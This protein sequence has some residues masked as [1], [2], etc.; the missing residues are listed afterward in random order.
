VTPAP[1]AAKDEKK[2]AAT[3]PLQIKIGD[4]ASVRFGILIQPQADFQ[5]NSSGDTAQNLLLRRT[6]FLVGGQVTSNVFFY[7]ETENSRL[8]AVNSA[9]SKVIS[10]G[11][12]TLAAVAEWRIKKP[13]NLQAGLLHVPTS[14]D[15]LKSAPSEFTIDSG[16]YAFTAST[17]M[18]GTSGRDTGVMARGFFLD[19][20]LEYRVA[21]LSGL[22]DSA[23]LNDFRTV[24]RLQYNVFDAEVY[25]LPSYA[26]ANFGTKKI[27]ALGVAVDSQE[28]YEGFTGDLF[29]DIPTGFG[30]AQGTVAFHQ[31]DGGTTSRTALAES[32]IL[33]ADAGLYFKKAKAGVWARYERRD[34]AASE[35]RD[36]E[37]AQLG[38]NYYPFGN[39]LNFK[40]AVGQVNPNVG[41]DMTQFTIQMQAFYY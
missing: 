14:R 21:V 40:F 6:R 39:N 15:V 7:F 27:M 33:S 37:R 5:E 19:D 30:S 2:P 10:S 12:Q 32:D 35:D 23:S 24:A 11:F 4:N 29:A 38:L 3:G 13:F 25:N 18:G 22:R 34:F 20:R 1:P 26:G 9:G 8:G 17:A 31:L 28:D 41:N 16:A 36:E